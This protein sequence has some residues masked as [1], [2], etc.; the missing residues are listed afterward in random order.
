MFKNKAML[1]IASS[2]LSMPALIQAQGVTPTASSKGGAV[3][4]DNLVDRYATLAG[5]TANAK[6][7]VNGLRNGANITLTGPGPDEPVFGQVQVGTK[8]VQVGTRS[9]PIY[10]TQPVYQIQ[11]RPCPPPQLPTMMCPTRV[12]VGTQQVQVGTRD[13]PVYETQPV[14][15]TRQ[16]GT[17]PGQP[18]SMTFSPGPAAP[19]GFGNV[20][21]ALA[22]TE[23]RLRPNAAPSATELKGSLLEIL[24]KRAGGEGWGEIAKGY[25]FELK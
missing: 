18:I 15:E 20:D 3:S 2:L 9:E 23:A 8:Q 4:T 12:Q 17:K 14:Y 5:G 6:S 10:E 13:V 22:L 1:L 16:I 25:G 11:M 24:G 7:V 21:I 19:M